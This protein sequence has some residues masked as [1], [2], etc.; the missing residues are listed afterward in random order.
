MK[1]STCEQTETHEIWNMVEGMNVFVNWNYYLHRR[2][3]Y[4]SVICSAD[5]RFSSYICNVKSTLTSI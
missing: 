5:P 3:C 1:F 2:A 4:M